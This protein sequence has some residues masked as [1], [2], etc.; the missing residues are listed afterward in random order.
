MTDLQLSVIFF[1][2]VIVLGDVNTSHRPRDHCDPTDIVSRLV[3]Y[4]CFACFLLGKMLISISCR[5][6]DDKIDT[7]LMSV[8]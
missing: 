5:E 4:E 1:S 3:S 7:A 2:H 6:L 8:R